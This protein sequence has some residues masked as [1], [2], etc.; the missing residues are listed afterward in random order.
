MLCV[1]FAFCMQVCVLHMC[2]HVWLALSSGGVSAF[3]CVCIYNRSCVLHVVACIA[4]PVLKHN[5]R[6]HDQLSI[7]HVIEVL[8]LAAAMHPTLDEACLQHCW[9]EQFAHEAAI[10][11]SI[12]AASC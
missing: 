1:Y 9:F 5:C 6:Q 4:H 3:S 2:M 7:I 8:M 12:V 10:C 11:V